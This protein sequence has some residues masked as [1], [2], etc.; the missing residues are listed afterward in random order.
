MEVLLDLKPEIKSW[1]SYSSF[2]TWRCKYSYRPV[3]PVSCKG[4]RPQLLFLFLFQPR[5][6]AIPEA[7][8]QLEQ[9]S[10]DRNA[11]ILSRW[12][13]RVYKM[14]LK[15]NNP[16][17]KTNKKTPAFCKEFPK[18]CL[19]NKSK[20]MNSVHFW[21]LHVTLNMQNEYPKPC[22][23]KVGIYRYCYSHVLHEFVL[24]TGLQRCTV[25]PPGYKGL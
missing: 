16:K 14:S 24:V 22:Y 25:I 13:N 10:K 2:G 17:N 20:H 21:F 15:K 6:P 23:R 4:Q 1:W 12:Q 9:K 5:F 11:H 19:K 8:Q 18:Q 3:M 7:L